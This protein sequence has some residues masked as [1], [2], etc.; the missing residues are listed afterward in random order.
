MSSEALLRAVAEE[1]E[2]EDG[3]LISEEGYEGNDDTCGREIDGIGKGLF[4]F[5]DGPPGPPSH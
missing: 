5:E 1:L 3:L 4:W 2:E